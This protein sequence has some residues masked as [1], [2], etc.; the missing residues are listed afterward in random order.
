MSHSVSTPGSIAARN[1]ELTHRAILDAAVE[2]LERAP[3]KELT[4]R[5]VAGRAGMS[6]RTLFR[7]FASHD[8]LLDAVIDEVVRRFDLPA[9]PTSVTELLAYPEALYARFD[10]IAAL[11]KAI[12]HSELYPRVRKTNTQ[13]RW[14]AV[15]GIVDAFAPERSERERT[16][17]AANIRY[18]LTATTWHYYR[19]QFGFAPADAVRCARI[20]ISQSLD[21][22]R[23]PVGAARG[24]VRGRSKPPKPELR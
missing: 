10:D 12:L 22:L 2:Q 23:A 5:A 17:A 18:Y 14:K 6:E 1:A 4:M 8:E 16:F 13:R 21:G 24:T 3:L 20:A 11:T 15:R 9:D 7:Y 19:F